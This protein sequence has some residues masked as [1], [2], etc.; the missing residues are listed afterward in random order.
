MLAH[1][2]VMD[3]YKN[4][5]EADNKNNYA[6]LL[7]AYAVFKYHKLRFKPVKEFYYTSYGYVIL[8]ILIEKVLGLSY[9][10]YMQTDIW[11]KAKMANTR[12][13]KPEVKQEH[14]TTLY[15]RVRKGKIKE[16]KT[17]NLSNRI[18]AGGF[19]STTNNLIN[20][21]DLNQ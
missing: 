12:I 17:I 5:K 9:E 20:S 19:Y 16:A 1:T 3:T 11:D 15:L 18:P 21:E 14:T 13:E 8:G 2:F 10:A 7:D 6:T 4:D